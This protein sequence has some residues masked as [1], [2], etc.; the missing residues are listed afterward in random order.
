MLIP[1]SV[2]VP[3]VRVPLANWVLIGVTSL[4]SLGVLITLYTSE[5][6]EN[7]LS[8][9][10]MKKLKEFEGKEDSPEARKFFDELVRESGADEPRFPGALEPRRF[11]FLQLFSHQFVHGDLIHLIGNMLFLFVFG[12]AVNAKLGHA[13][14][15]ACYLF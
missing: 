3:M 2:D 14:F 5:H 15:L 7:P 4:V 11:S 1:Y 10:L 13:T 9:Q 8:P 6:S 12:N